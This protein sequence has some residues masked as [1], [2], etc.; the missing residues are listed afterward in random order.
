MNTYSGFGKLD[1]YPTS[2]VTEF[3]VIQ[4][5]ILVRDISVPS[6][7]PYAYQ[8]PYLTV[9]AVRL[10]NQIF[11]YTTTLKCPSVSDPL[12]ALIISH[13]G[14]ALLQQPGLVI[15]ADPA[16]FC[17]KLLN[18]VFWR[19]VFYPAHPDIETRSPLEST[20]T[21]LARGLKDILPVRALPG[22]VS[23]SHARSVGQLRATLGY[24]IKASNIARNA[25]VDMAWV[26]QFMHVLGKQ[27]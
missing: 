1:T 6:Y 24:L 27:P 17:C 23:I 2:L 14:R 16:L 15:C 19:A 20:V 21:G 7:S 22:G 8:R 18:G 10:T 9:M 12:N 13:Q 4:L 11:C 26:A 25:R 3:D 5:D